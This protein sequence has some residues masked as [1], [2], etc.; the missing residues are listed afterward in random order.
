MVETASDKHA[1]PACCGADVYDQG[2]LQHDGA[3]NARFIAAL[4][5][6]YRAGLLVEVQGA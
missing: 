3:A 4:V 5:N 6:A 2:R 1:D